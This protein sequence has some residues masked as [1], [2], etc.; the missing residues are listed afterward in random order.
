MKHAHKNI[1]STTLPA[2]QAALS[3]SESVAAS[4]LW[5]YLRVFGSVWGISIP[6]AI[7][8]SRFAV[9]SYRIS[10]SAVRDALGGGNAYSHVSGS[11]VA[12]LPQALQNEVRGVYA[13]ALR[14]VWY[15]SMALS[16]VA[17]AIVFLE[18]EIVMRTTIE[19]PEPKGSENAAKD[20]ESKGGERSTQPSV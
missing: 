10:D 18:K 7:F 15:V 5:A 16:V 3:D 19:A 2:A 13:D 17:F 9:E 20:T 12:S 4:A 1:V 11:F 6:A 8:N 14:V